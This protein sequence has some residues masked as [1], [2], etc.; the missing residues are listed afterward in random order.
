ML[1]LTIVS[2]EPRRVQPGRV[3]TGYMDGVSGGGDLRV[4]GER[5]PAALALALVVPGRVAMP[6]AAKP[7]GR[8]RALA[9]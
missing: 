5:E 3:C 7:P 4:G 6:I 8:G 1:G 9:G 2:S